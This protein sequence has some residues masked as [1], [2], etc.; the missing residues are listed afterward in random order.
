MGD[1]FL[2]EF[3]NTLDAVRCAYDI[4]RTTRE[5]NISLPEEQR[6]HLRVGIHLGDVVESVGDI[7]GDAVNVASRIVPLAEDGGVSLTRQVYDQVHNK[8]DLPLTSL[9]SKKLKNVAAPAEVFK[10]VMP[11]SE[12]KASSQVQ[13]ERNKVAVLPFANMSP[14]PGDEYFADGMTEELIAAL[15]KLRGVG[16]ISQTSV[17]QYK[18]QTKNVGDI[19]REL[20]AGTLLEGSVRKAGN[21][22]RIAVQLIDAST[23]NHL[24]AE[25]YGIGEGKARQVR[26]AIDKGTVQAKLNIIPVRRGCGSWECRCPFKALGVSSTTVP[27]ALVSIGGTS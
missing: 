7:S 1:A 4:Q 22:V 10:M 24:W 17:M 18:N 9:G 23:D 14:D 16:V 21:R 25:N 20:G 5:F 13:L 27:R 2:V 19:G 8:F 12:K 26:T 11:W 6:I 15:S 3:S